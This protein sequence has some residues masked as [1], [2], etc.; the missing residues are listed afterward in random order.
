MDDRR[1]GFEPCT[2]HGPQKRV[3]LVSRLRGI[4]ALPQL[5]DD[6]AAAS[7]HGDSGKTPA[8]TYGIVRHKLEGNKLSYGDSVVKYGVSNTGGREKHLEQEAQ[9]G[10]IRAIRPSPALSGPITDAYL[11]LSLSLSLPP[12]P[13]TPTVDAAPGGGCRSLVA[14][15]WSLGQQT[16]KRRSRLRTFDGACVLSF[17]YG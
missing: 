9:R 15:L 10:E 4:T 5:G 13:L 2:N 12:P 1:V 8:I 11:P 14:G 17:P 3:R 6:E 7:R 16:D